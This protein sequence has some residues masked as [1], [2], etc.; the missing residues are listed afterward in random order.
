MKPISEGDLVMV[1]TP[2]HCGNIE[3]LGKVFRVSNIRQARGCRHCSQ[4]LDGL[5][6]QGLHKDMGVS[7]S[8]LKRIDPGTLDEPTAHPEELHEV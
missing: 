4:W 2:G 7:M 5:V 3:N 8:R 6:A 1:V